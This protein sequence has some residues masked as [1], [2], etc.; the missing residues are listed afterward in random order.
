MI[1]TALCGSPLLAFMSLA[2]G[3]KVV[4]EEEGL[5]LTTSIGAATLLLF[6]VLVA[7]LGCGILEVVH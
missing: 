7:G 1:W 2:V 5:I 6:V 3:I 4:G